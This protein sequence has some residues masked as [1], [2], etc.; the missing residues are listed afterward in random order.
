MRRFSSPFIVISDDSGTKI[1]DK[2][3][4]EDIFERD[5]ESEAAEEEELVPELP[6]QGVSPPPAACR[7]PRASSVQEQV[8]PILPMKLRRQ[9][10]GVTALARS[11][12]EFVR[13]ATQEAQVCRCWMQTDWSPVSPTIKQPLSNPLFLSYLFS[14]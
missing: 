14:V 10:C 3:Q 7:R 2:V 12:A 5:A 8:K 13:Q 6:P 1:K 11:P 4:F 9:S